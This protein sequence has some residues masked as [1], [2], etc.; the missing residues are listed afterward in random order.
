MNLSSLKHG[1]LQSGFLIIIFS[2]KNKDVIPWEAP[3][4]TIRPKYKVL[5]VKIFYFFL[6]VDLCVRPQVGAHPQVR[7]YGQ[8]ASRNPCLIGLVKFQPG[9]LAGSPWKGAARA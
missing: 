8:I 7:P 9:A 6:G 3:G 1:G 2:Q 5:F 4:G